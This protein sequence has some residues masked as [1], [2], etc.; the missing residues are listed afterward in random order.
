MLTISLPCSYRVVSQL[1]LH[2]LSS[3]ALEN[4]GLELLVLN[5]AGVVGVDHL[6]E[7]V[8][9]LALNTDLQLGNKVSYLVDGQV[10]ALV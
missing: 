7:G 9:V 2:F 4:V 3:L 5:A 8:D 10:S 6:E 1:G